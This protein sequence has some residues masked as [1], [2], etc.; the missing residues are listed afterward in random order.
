MPGDI[1]DIREA[2]A[3]ARNDIN[4]LSGKCGDYAE[5]S[6]PTKLF[7]DGDHLKMMSNDGLTSYSQADLS[8]FDNAVESVYLS[9]QNPDP[10]G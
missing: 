10:T 1:A 6:A 5:L 2:L 7:L 3:E 9:V 4:G 8:E